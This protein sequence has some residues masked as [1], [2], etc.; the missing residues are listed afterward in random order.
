LIGFE[1]ITQ[2]TQNLPYEVRYSKLLASTSLQNPF[3]ISIICILFWFILVY[4]G[5]F[6]FILVYFVLLYIF[7]CFY[8]LYFHEIVASRLA[9]PYGD[10]L[11]G[12]AQHV[13]DCGGEGNYL[14][15][16]SLLTCIPHFVTALVLSLTVLININTGVI[17]HKLHSL[18]EHGRTQSILKFKVKP[19]FFHFN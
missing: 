17:L 12:F 15:C 18:Y 3:V 8:F 1:E 16:L 10:Q 11:N 4:F 5:L 6:W 19:F 9:L 13:I 2:S 14:L 7:Q